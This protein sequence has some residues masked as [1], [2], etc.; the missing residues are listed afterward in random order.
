MFS[1]RHG[2]P[3]NLQKDPS[4]DKVEFA[5]YYLKGFS[6][7][8][9]TIIFGLLEQYRQKIYVSPRIIQLSLNYLRERY[10]HSLNI[11]HPSYSIS[12]VRHA[13]SWKIMQNNMV[14]LIQDI[15]YPLLCI[16]D[17]EIE[18]FTDEPVE[19]VRSRLGKFISFCISSSM[20]AVQIS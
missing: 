14:V 12:S 5:N 19:Y 18:T 17:E 16:T 9:I 3:A 2:A 1:S 6:G 15:I 4:A 11:H 13:F 10:C 7:K 8:V 20:R